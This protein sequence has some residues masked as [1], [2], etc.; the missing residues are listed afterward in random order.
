MPLPLAVQERDLAFL[1]LLR[2]TVGLQVIVHDER[3]KQGLEG[4]FLIFVCTMY[5]YAV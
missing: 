3:R 1:V 5:V 2:S 4:G